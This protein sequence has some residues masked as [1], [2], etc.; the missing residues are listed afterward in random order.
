LTRRC[1][2]DQHLIVKEEMIFLMNFLKSLN[3][4]EK[5][6]SLVQCIRVCVYTII[7]MHDPDEDYKNYTYMNLHIR[8]HN[9]IIWMID[10]Y[11]N[12]ASV[13]KYYSILMTNLLN[14]T[15]QSILKYTNT[16]EIDSLKF[17]DYNY[18]LI[19]LVYFNMVNKLK[20]KSSININIKNV[21]N[22]NEDLNQTEDIIKY[23]SKQR[24]YTYQKYC[25]IVL[26]MNLILVEH[27]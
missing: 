20:T 1:L 24:I 6:E 13:N 23:L 18:F 17:V 21:F 9:G 4:I 27:V 19:K 15:K 26:N 11:F 22:L 3:S 25:E 8:Q 14:P 5:S 10:N 2:N 7:E 12:K 16:F